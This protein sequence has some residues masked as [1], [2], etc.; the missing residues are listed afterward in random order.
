MK[1]RLGKS[2]G[3]PR[4]PVSAGSKGSIR[5]HSASFSSCRC[6]PRQKPPDARLRKFSVRA[7]L[8]RQQER[9]LLRRVPCRQQRR[10]QHNLTPNPSPKRR[11]E[12]ESGGQG[13]TEPVKTWWESRRS[14]RSS[15][16]AR[17]SP[18]R[19]GAGGEVALQCPFEPPA[20]ETSTDDLPCRGHLSDTLSEFRDRH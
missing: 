9:P 15:R 13:T 7:C 6:I 2:A 3:R 14:K 16:Q 18:S 10:S 20:A 11:G 8:K 12:P 19:R 4:R 5:A 1:V 17:P